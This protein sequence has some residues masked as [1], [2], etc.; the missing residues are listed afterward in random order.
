M[1]KLK[2][3]KQGDPFPTDFWNYKINPILGYEYES[4]RKKD[5]D[6]WKYQQPTNQ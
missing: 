3:L 6:F 4:R 5:K 2:K 1:P